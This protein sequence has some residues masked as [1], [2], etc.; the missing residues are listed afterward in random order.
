MKFDTTLLID[1][2][3]GRTITAIP[4]LEKFVKKNPSTCIINYGWTPILF[5]NPIL[6][7]R[8]FD[9]QTKGL[10]NRIKDSKI[11]KIE[12]YYNSDYINGRINLAD[13]FNQDI[14]NDK[15]KMPVPKIYLSE[16]ELRNGKVVKKGINKTIAFQPFGSTAQIKDDIVE[17]NTLRSLNRET[18][19]AIVKFLK[20]EG[21]N[22]YLITDKM[23]P[24]LNKNDFVDY[25]APFVRELSAAISHCDYLIGVDSSAQHIAR[26]Y[27]IPGT[28]IVGGTNPVNISYP[29]FFNLYNHDKNR[30]Y[31]PYRITDFDFW[32]SEVQNA[33]IL[34]FDSK[35]IKDC[36]NN[37]KAHLRKHI[38]RA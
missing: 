16:Q 12:P 38:K 10:F 21:Y 8:V 19:E 1:G 33:N 5:G 36:V 35:K 3:L 6:T 9:S 26:S 14:N 22:I 37:I 25:A 20:S 24:W 2:G 13:A 23:I 17:D 28:I 11:I 29:D 27:N 18:T 4:A 7:D 32:L 34:N 31:M 30:T 15:E